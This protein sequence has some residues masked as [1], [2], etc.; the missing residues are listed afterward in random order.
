MVFWYNLFV[1]T[2]VNYTNNYN[3]FQL[4][5]P[6]NVDVI[7][8]KDDVL[9]SFLELIGKV[10]LNKYLIRSSSKT[11]LAYDPRMMLTVVLFAYTNQIYSLRNI[12][13]SCKTDIRF[14]FLTGNKNP[15]HQAFYRF[16]NNYLISSIE[17][18]FYDIN[19][20]LINLDSIDTDTLYIDGTKF[21]ANANKYTFVW[22]KAV[23]KFQ[24]RLFVKISKLLTDINLE[25]TTTFTTKSSY[26]VDTLTII[27]DYLLNIIDKQDIVFVYG[28]G[29]RKT[30]LQRYYELIEEYITKLDE[31][32]T[33]LDIC[34]T[35]NSYSKIDN[36][37]TFMNM[38][39]DYYNRTGV[40]KPGY[41][42]Q[43][44]I[45]DEYIMIADVYQNPGDTKTFIPLMDKYQEEYNN[46][47]KYPVGDAG[48]GSYDNYSYC[49][50]NGMELSL[51]YNYFNKVNYDK[52]FSKNKY[53]SMN[54][55][56][57][58]DGIRICPASYK[59]DILVDEHNSESGLYLQ[60]K[61]VYETG[62]CNECSLKVDCT[63]AKGNRKL[64]VCDSLDKM[65]EKVDNL[66]TSDLGIELRKQRSIQVEGAFGVIKE[67]FK[68]DRIHRRGMEKVKT[69]ILMV[70]IGYN[71]KKYHNKK[72]RKKLS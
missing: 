41:N 57:L 43:L 55:E 71:I 51:K 26:T 19:K 69:E 15:S 23:L 63:K 4:T 39:Y 33:H 16:I 52:K 58:A 14:M 30:K 47:P 54:F 21:E 49:L 40:F 66:L 36:D 65:Y 42:I 31:Y 37:A 48:Y 22:K 17:D 24:E 35:R 72:N 8:P 13:H 6:L 61:K 60:H 53:H 45:S 12:E 29:T 64:T 11:N 1:L 34:G 56:K 25:Y 38:K 62:K 44:G 20:C 67:D 46:L 9:H 32:T 18:I 68:Y 50:E 3:S 2:N 5:L 7:I 59:F 27:K 28:K 70:C 10:N